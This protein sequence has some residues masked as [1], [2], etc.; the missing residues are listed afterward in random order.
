MITL[1]NKDAADARK[2]DKIFAKIEIITIS[3]VD[4]VTDEINKYQPLMIRLIM[5]YYREFGGSMIL[6]TLI[7]N[8][9]IMWEF[10]KDNKA[11]K[12]KT[13]TEAMFN[14]R[15]SKIMQFFETLDKYS[16]LEK[17]ELT[18]DDFS[19]IKHKLLMIRMLERFR[20]NEYLTQLSNT[21]RNQ[22][23]I[24]TRCMIDCLASLSK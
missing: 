16:G 18:I 23:L 20:S 19:T 14:S 13:I 3:E 4:K 24:E 2:L 17:L 15:L 21:Q 11:V 6:E 8:I 12:G 5:A 7:K 9:L 1:N 10:F 22:L